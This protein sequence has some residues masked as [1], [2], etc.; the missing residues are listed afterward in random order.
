MPPTGSA[1]VR[2]ASIASTTRL[3]RSTR[4]SFASSL[5]WRAE[6]FQSIARRSMPG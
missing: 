6:A 1:I 4:Y 2:P 5:T 3:S